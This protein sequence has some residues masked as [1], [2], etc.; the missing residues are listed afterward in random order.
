MPV[1][2]TASISVTRKRDGL[3]QTAS[4]TQFAP[5]APAARGSGTLRLIDKRRVRD[6]QTINRQG[7]AVSVVQRVSSDLQGSFQ[8]LR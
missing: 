3:V 5:T 4:S 2:G 7:V 1:K 6:E 8:F